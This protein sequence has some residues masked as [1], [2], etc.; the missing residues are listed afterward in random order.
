MKK[1]VKKILSFFVFTTCILL[2]P[3][4]VNAESDVFSKFPTY[5]KDGKEYLDIKAINPSDTP[6]EF[7][8][9]VYGD[10]EESQEG[11]RNDY[12]LR[13]LQIILKEQLGT[14]FEDYER[15]S[16]KVN[17]NKINITY[18]PIDYQLA[19]DCQEKEYNIVWEEYKN[20]EEL[21]KLSKE[22]KETYT[23][24]G[25]TH[26]NMAYHIDNFEYYNYLHGNM[27]K[28]NYDLVL[29]YYPGFKEILEEY[30]EY[31]F[32]LISAPSGGGPLQ[33]NG[34]AMVGIIKDGVLLNAE[35][36]DFRIHNILFVPIDG[37]NNLITS[38]ENLLKKSFKGEKEI[39]IIKNTDF[40]TYVLLNY[41]DKINSEIVQSAAMDDL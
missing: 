9:N 36:V 17:D 4:V 24:Y 3:N 12:A 15:Y 23:V 5:E 29:S 1:N 26:I 27:E 14:S 40:D 28:G 6:T 32:V 38:A 30:P 37:N 39:K 21:V 2:L 8:N 16:Y 22:I 7:C 35:Y 19:T 41:F 34:G 33:L 20:K 18:C 25:E 13:Y 11:C 10:D 31:E